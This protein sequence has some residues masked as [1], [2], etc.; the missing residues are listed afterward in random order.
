MIVGD[1]D[2]HSL[3]R[4]QFILGP[5]FFVMFIFFSVFVLLNMFLAIVNESYT[6]V[7]ERMANR[8]TQLKL[9]DMLKKSTK[10]M[11]NRMKRKTSRKP[12]VQILRS[13]GSFGKEAISFEEHGYRDAEITASFIK[14]D[15]DGDNSLNLEE[16]AKLEDETATEMRMPIVEIEGNEGSDVKEGDLV[17]DIS[18]QDEP[19][20]VDVHNFTELEARVSVLQQCVAT[21][22]AQSDQILV[23]LEQAEVAKR[24]IRLETANVMRKTSGEEQDAEEV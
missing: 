21:M 16:Q 12:L 13:I 2:F 22:L 19:E 7:K 14:Y 5:L 18:Q 1:I 6:K 15:L 17:H 8:G 11:I 9:E 20:Y 24:D 10:E 23:M 4:T 3:Q